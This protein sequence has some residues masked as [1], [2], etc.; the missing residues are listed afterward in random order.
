MEQIMNAFR[1]K[2]LWICQ[3]ELISIN[4]LQFFPI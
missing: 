3:I 4:N 2:D 1:N